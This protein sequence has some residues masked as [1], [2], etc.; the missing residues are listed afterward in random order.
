MET[1]RKIEKICAILG[2]A[3][4]LIVTITLI[5]SGFKRVEGPKASLTENEIMWLLK[6]NNVTGYSY[7]CSDHETDYGSVVIIREK[8]HGILEPVVNKK[9]ARV[10]VDSSGIEDGMI[11]SLGT[12]VFEDGSV[13]KDVLFINEPLGLNWV[14]ISIM[15]GNTN[16]L[17]TF[18]NND[19]NIY[20]EVLSY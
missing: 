11:Y 5:S 7:S 2:L 3:L 10:T 1:I 18:Y 19:V 6:N 17:F 14:A 8:N 4:M 9:I 20:G 15:R 12:I 16:N 13:E